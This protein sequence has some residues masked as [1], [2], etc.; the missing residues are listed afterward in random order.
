MMRHDT[1]MGHRRLN[2]APADGDGAAMSRFAGGRHLEECRPP[3]APPKVDDRNVVAEEVIP[4]SI[5]RR[6]RVVRGA[7]G[8]LLAALL[9]LTG[10]GLLVAAAQDAG[11]L[12]PAPS[13][14]T[15]TT[16]DGPSIVVT[17]F[18]TVTEAA[19]SATLQLIV[20][21]S[22]G[23]GFGAGSYAVSGAA[24]GGAV[25]IENGGV[26]SV[27]E[28][29]PAAGGVAEPAPPMAEPGAVPVPGAVMVPRVTEERVQPMVDAMVEAGVDNDRIEVAIS[30]SSA[31]GVGGNAALITATVASPTTEVVETIVNAA[32]EAAIGNGLAIFETGALYSLADCAAPKREAR[33]QAIANAREQAAELAELLGV[34]LGEMLQA[35]DYGQ[36]AYNPFALAGAEGCTSAGDSFG[37][38][39]FAGG[40]GLTIPQFNPA[41][42]A[43]AR[44]VSAVSMVFAIE[45]A[46][47]STPSASA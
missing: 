32:S 15:I 6:S 20:S 35:S 24:E 11:E 8:V 7:V 4:M 36:G 10:G 46:D 27:V 2:E 34:E 45:S 38:S 19:D 3:V 31:V 30:P 28:A 47:A 29:T 12:L 23:M 16:V 17:G 21:D 44:V 37:S 39:V 18:G 13:A 41:Q 26:S 5:H 33:T 25:V 43:E 1:S 40:I 9:S 14:Q 22:M 42:P